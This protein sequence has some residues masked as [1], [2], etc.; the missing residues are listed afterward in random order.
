MFEVP[1][2]GKYRVYLTQGMFGGIYTW[3][4]VKIEAVKVPLFEKALD[5]DTI[6]VAAYGEVLAS[7]FGQKP[8]EAIARQMELEYA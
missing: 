3:H 4:F 1:P 8:P 6:D 7:G 5:S 2:R